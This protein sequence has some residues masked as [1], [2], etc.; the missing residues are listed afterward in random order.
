MSAR[1]LHL[2][3][4]P[5]SGIAGDMAVAALVDAGVPAAVVR[6]AVAAMGVRGLRV[7]FGRRKRGAY[8]GRSFEVSWPG[9][10]RRARGGKRAKASTTNHAHSHDH[11]HDH[12]HDHE[13]DQEHDHGAHEHR[14]YAEIKRLLT[15]AR[16]DADVRALAGEIFAHIAEVE[17]ALHGT[18]VDRVA[19]HEVGAYDSIADVV[20]VAAAIVHLAPSSI[21][22]LPPVVGSGFVR[23]A[24]GPVPVPAPATAALLVEAQIP[25]LAD[26]E[27]ELTTPT[28]AAILAAVVDDF[29]PLPPLVPRAI[30]YGAGTKE[31]A[32]RANVLRVTLGTP[33]GAPD[34]TPAGDVVLVEANVDDMSPQLV[35]PLF[36]ALFA[37]GAVDAWSSPILMKK[38]RPAVQ[39]SAL[40]PPGV[41]AAVE[42]AFFA[43]STTLGLRRRA[44]ERVVLARSFATVAT[45]YGKVRI[46]LA[47]LDGEILGAQ[48]EFEDCRRLAAR[49]RVPA[50]EVL[51]AA[52]AAARALLPRPR[53]PRRSQ[54]R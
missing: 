41:L 7:A 35:G 12:D 52:A 19:F 11:D 6:D 9:Q 46:K 34:V 40:A 29:G 49:T 4:E 38:G 1:G 5:T 44:L 39:V 42:R 15:R 25:M 22:S 54:R 21:G 24:H 30:G 14:D 32:D 16:L 2:H 27:G 43:N 36:D 20:G 51:A 50:R 26:G 47:A 18:R 45:P 53:R 48:P 8:V 10:P 33:L 28:G 3:F 13:H 31:L 37:A 17:A 23:T